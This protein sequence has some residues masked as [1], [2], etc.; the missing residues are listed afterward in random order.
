MRRAII[1][2]RSWRDDAAVLVGADVA[3]ARSSK[4]FSRIEVCD[5]FRRMRRAKGTIFAFTF[6]DGVLS[7]VAHDLRIRLEKFEIT[8][9][10]NAV[11]GEFDLKSL[12][13]DGPMENG[14][15]QPNQYDASKRADV[16]K[17]M[18]GD[19]LHTNKNPTA[20]FTG[21][22]TPK[23]SGY[24]VAGEL[25]LAGKKAPLSFEVQGEGGTYRTSFEIQPSQWGIAQYKALLGAIKLKDVVRIEAA[26]S[27]A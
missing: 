14:V 27:E 18:H 6:K 16:E 3:T 12:F 15:L 11:R 1:S 22:A 20:L 23:G 7:A 24:S 5:S 21:T 25:E 9:D 8:L 2:T 4:T 10:G 26:L 19:V 13:V 17:A